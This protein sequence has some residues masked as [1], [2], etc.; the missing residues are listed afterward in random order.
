MTAEKKALKSRLFKLCIVAAVVLPVC[1]AGF[2]AARADV[3]FRIKSYFGLGREHIEARAVSAEEIKTESVSYE[4]FAG[5]ENVSENQALML[6]NSEN[7]LGEGFSADISE[8]R[9]SG[10]DMNSCMTEDYGRLSD[11]VKERFGEKLLVTSSYR[12]AD[13]QEEISESEGGTAA[14]KGASEHQAGLALDVCVKG[15]AGEGFIKSEVGRFVNTD[16]QDFGFIIRYPQGAE[17]VTG[18]PYEPWHIRYVGLPHSRLIMSEG[19]TLEEYIDSLEVGKFYVFEDYI[20]TRQ[21]K[22]SITVPSGCESY[23]VSPDNKGGVIITG[24]KSK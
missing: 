22:G 19:I 2:L 18:I 12:T 17:D 23:T 15:F 11:C 1:G 7:T 21:E 8:Y 5:R 16:C 13:E 9:Q 6:I 24:K 3:R 14:V 20:F 10:V 4:E